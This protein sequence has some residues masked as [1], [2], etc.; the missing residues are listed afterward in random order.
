MR[1]ENTSNWKC[2]LQSEFEERDQ[3][4][5]V[6]HE[7]SSVENWHQEHHAAITHSNP[8]ET[9]TIGLWPN[10]NCEDHSSEAEKQKKT[11]VHEV[12]ASFIIIW[13]VVVFW[14][15]FGGSM[16]SILINSKGVLALLVV[17]LFTMFRGCTHLSF[18]NSGIQFISK[19]LNSKKVRKSIRW[20][21]ISRIYL[22]DKTKAGVLEQFLCFST[23]YG[24]THK[25]KLRKIANRHQ[26]MKVLE[27]LEKWYGLS[28]NE[29]NKDIFDAVS[30]DR[31]SPTYT[32][33]WLEALSAPPRRERL[34]PLVEG[35][36]VRQGRYRLIRLL[37]AGGQGSAFLAS[38]SDGSLVV[39]KEYILPIY[40]DRQV[41]K[42][43]IERFENEARMLAKLDH[44]SIV[45]LIDFFLDDHRAY[46]V[47]E[48]IDGA[49]LQ[50]TVAEHGPLGDAMAL[51]Y[52]NVCIEILA[53]LHNQ[54]PPIV[55][56]DFTPD[57]IMV[58]KDGTLK[59]I[60]FMVA[61]QTD[62]ASTSSTIVGK[63][64][65]MAPEQ[66]RGRNTPQS[67]IYAFGCTLFYLLTG[68][69]PE[70]I[71]QLHPILV[72][73]CDPSFDDIVS[74]CTEAQPVDRYRSVEEI[75]ANLNNVLLHPHRQ[76]VSK[77]N[78]SLS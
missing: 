57:N 52:A 60:D 59:L 53:Y 8:D 6:N 1:I 76:F 39:L 3:T 44:R 56:R 67:D 38:E 46:L 22:S 4:E 17:P 41:R 66:F 71:T 49:T 63:H 40:V 25:I 75:R 62:D 18:N 11:H 45:K 12:V 19:D 73:D 50:Q 48:Y 26:W 20:S 72:K 55:H 15:I 36:C 29:L 30:Q 37:G 61:Q 10:G 32:M 9:I 74:K 28:I 47:L 24:A 58:T 69:E 77:P 68:S 51:E 23:M 35:S 54:S 31:K 5:E 7:K 14:K 42:Q 64:S 78:K 27:A 43:A 34:N 2:D 13:F 16:F 65:Y 70:P 21:D 33:L